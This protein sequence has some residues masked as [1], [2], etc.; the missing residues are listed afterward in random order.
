MS[1]ITINSNLASLQVGRRLERNTNVLRRSFER[2]SSGLR[3]NRASDDAAGLAVSAG[4]EVDA[5]VFSQGI[6][7]LNDGIGMLNIAD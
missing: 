6:R 2:L 5:R 1:R 7:N 4:L 3:I